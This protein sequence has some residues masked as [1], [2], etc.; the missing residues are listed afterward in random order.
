MK[1]WKVRWLMQVRKYNI[2]MAEL[3]RVTGINYGYLRKIKCDYRS[4][5]NV[6]EHIIW[7]TNKIIE[8]QERK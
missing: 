1:P 3:S 6:R 2:K 4:G 8:E 7:G 5:N